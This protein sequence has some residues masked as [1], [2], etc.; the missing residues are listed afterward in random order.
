M[1]RLESGRQ[2]VIAA[3]SCALLFAMSAAALAKNDKSPPPP[4][5]KKG[6]AANTSGKAQSI[7][8][9]VKSLRQLFHWPTSHP[10]PPVTESARAP[11]GFVRAPSRSQPYIPVS[12]RIAGCEGSAGFS[13]GCRAW[14]GFVNPRDH[15]YLDAFR[16]RVLLTGGSQSVTW[17]GADGTQRQAWVTAGPIVTMSVVMVPV[18]VLTMP[19]TE[20]EVTPPPESP[21]GAGGPYSG[22]VPPS[23]DPGGVPPP[24]PGAGSQEDPAIHQSSP[25]APQTFS[26]QGGAPLPEGGA[27]AVSQ[28][29]QAAAATPMPRLCREVTMQVATAADQDQQQELW[30]RNDEGDWAPAMT[31]AV[32]AR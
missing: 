30:C 7:Q 4:P 21:Y 14:R 12:R 27:G 5:P 26:Q 18:A 13:S 16:R 28:P 8:N 20:Q 9:P 1:K 22:V 10:A 29:A 31:S 19:V 32:A 25:S 2:E 3:L 11:A 17:V 24:A 6:A 15:Q 23:A